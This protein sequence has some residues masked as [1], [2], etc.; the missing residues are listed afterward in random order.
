MRKCLCVDVCLCGG[1]DARQCEG[2]RRREWVASQEVT[3]AWILMTFTQGS[4]I[5]IAKRNLVS[6]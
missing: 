3:Q 2:E 4:A 6:V 1:A 5:P